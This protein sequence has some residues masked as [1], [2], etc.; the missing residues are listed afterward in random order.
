MLF[1]QDW[2]D[3]ELTKMLSQTLNLLRRYSLMCSATHKNT[4][5]LKVVLRKQQGGY[6]ESRSGPETENELHMNSPIVRRRRSVQSMPCAYGQVHVS[7]R[8][9]CQSACSKIRSATGHLQA[10][11]PVPCVSLVII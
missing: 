11:R 6:T 3:T 7:F 5:T 1:R 8:G 9:L 4:K 2:S 10:S